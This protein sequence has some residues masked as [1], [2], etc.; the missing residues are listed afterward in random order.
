MHKVGAVI[1]NATDN[2]ILSTFVGLG[3][4]ALYSNYLLITN[5]LKKII[6]QI[7]DSVIASIGN[8]V[9]EGNKEKIYV[10]FDKMFFFNYY[11]YTVVCVCL[12][13]L[14]NDF[15]NLWVGKEFLF[16][17][18]LVFV[19]VLNFY[20]SGMRRTVLAFKD[21]MGLY[22]QDRFKPIFEAIINII[23]SIV[24]GIKFGTIGVLIGTFISNVATNLW[25]EPLTLYKY[26]FN[27]SPLKYYKKFIMHL[28]SFLVYT[29]LVNYIVSFY[30]TEITIL[31]F[32]IKGVVTFIL[33]NLVLILLNIKNKSFLYYYELGKKI[34]LRK[35]VS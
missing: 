21:A 20:L 2:I 34:I 27:D 6:A 11:I 18:T 17:S 24:L 23:F 12:F 4:V 35:K 9:S 5:N 15:I 26:G 25:I 7:F 10:V 30:F 13:V 22:W 1:I 29:S 33:I 32:I 31:M 16:N 19:V 3:A 8:L 14:F 28:I